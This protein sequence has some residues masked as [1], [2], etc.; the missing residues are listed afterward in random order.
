MALRFENGN[1]AARYLY[2]PAVD[3]ILAEER[4]DAATGQTSNLYW[5]LADNQGSVRDIAEYDAA[6][7]ETQIVESIDYSA[8]GKPLAAAQGQ[9]GGGGSGGGGYG[10]GGSG[11][12]GQGGGGSGGGGQGGGSSSTVDFIFGYTAREEDDDVGLMW[13]RARWYDGE[14]GRFVSEDPISFSAGDTNV[15]RYV[16][17]GPVNETDPSGL[18]EQ[19]KKESVYDAVLIRAGAG[20]PNGGWLYDFYYYRAGRVVG[21]KREEIKFDPSKIP[22]ARSFAGTY[23]IWLDPNG[24]RIKKPRVAWDR[25]RLE[26]LTSFNIDDLNS[27]GTDSLRE[28][29]KIAAEQ[30]AALAETYYT[31]SVSFLPGG[32][33]VLLANDVAEGNLGAAATDVA[34]GHADKLVRVAGIKIFAIVV[35]GET[36]RLAKRHI[37]ALGGCP[38]E[39]AKQLLD[40]AT[41]LWRRYKSR[42]VTK[43]FDD[44]LDE[45]LTNEARIRGS[46]GKTFGRISADGFTPPRIFTNRHGYLTNGVYVLDD[47]AMVAHTTGSLAA[48]KS[49]FL[50]RVN[51]KQLVLDAAAYA[52]SAGLWVGNK[53]TIILD[54]HIGVHGRT[55]EL[56]N[57]LNIYR[58]K[59][60]FIHGI[61][62]SPR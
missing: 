53:A 23:S 49:Q 9:Q 44:V 21:I 54:R 48:G 33:L 5:P 14:T 19:D 3:Q 20:G 55:G 30:A 35:D 47:A 17:N 52:D 4:V 6:T 57:V 46:V 2:G 27:L 62:G 58:N 32:D 51:E 60:G 59:N 34:V 22:G 18:K 50:F 16:G 39:R 56:T 38:K 31:V 12:G 25:R 28:N 13:Y 1:L 10:G 40:K 29:F 26:D 43:T 42:G 61:P 7:D 37:E 15:N 36:F 45:V 24:K 41:D 8:F 11:G